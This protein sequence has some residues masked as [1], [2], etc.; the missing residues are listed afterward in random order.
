MPTIHLITKLQKSGIKVAIQNKRLVVTGTS[1]NVHQLEIG[2]Y[3][4]YISHLSSPNQKVEPA[5]DAHLKYLNDTLQAGNIDLIVLTYN[6]GT[7]PYG[8]VTS[9]APSF[10]SQF[11]PTRTKPA[12]QDPPPVADSLQSPTAPQV[13]R[14][15]G[16]I[17]NARISSQPDA[18]RVS[19]AY[20]TQPG[21]MSL[22]SPT[23]T[24]VPPVLGTTPNARSSYQ[25][26]TPLVSPA[27]GAQPG[28]MSLQSLTAPQVPRGWV[29][30]IPNARISYQPDAPLVS[31]VT[32]T[33][34]ANA[35]LHSYK[36]T[37]GLVPVVL[38]VVLFCYFSSGKPQKITYTVL[39]ACGDDNVCAMPFHG[40]KLP[41][42]TRF[43]PKN[44]P[45][46]LILDEKTGYLKGPASVDSSAKVTVEVILGRFCGL[47]RGKSQNVE[48]KRQEQG[49]DIEAS[50]TNLFT[51]AIGAVGGGVTTLAIGFIVSQLTQG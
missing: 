43:K 48:V 1:K 50:S 31:P 18:P 35:T 3:I 33:G 39:S 46:G 42:G 44:L 49:S 9:K 10:L 2:D 24:Q 21:V 27:Y 6:K 23:A 45:L 41:W 7:K 38:I 13:H 19:P 22:W 37:A 51:A 36:K 12:A 16:T 34:T 8:S 4:T 47:F 26:D 32:A 28:V 40:D 25:P 5:T 29:T 30:T 11:L 14:V 20:G 17:P 15:W